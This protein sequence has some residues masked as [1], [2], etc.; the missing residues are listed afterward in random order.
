MSTMDIFTVRIL[1]D[2]LSNLVEHGLDSIDRAG[3]SPNIKVTVEDVQL[4][5]GQLGRGQIG[6]IGPVKR[7]LPVAAFHEAVQ[8]DLN[9]NPPAEPSA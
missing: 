7:F 8:E 5:L 1:L 9:C 6:D 4:A 3:I 2:C